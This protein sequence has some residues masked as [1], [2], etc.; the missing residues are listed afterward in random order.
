MENEIL[1]SRHRILIELFQ[2][3]IKDCEPHS[4]AYAL[5]ILGKDYSEDEVDSWLE[6]LATDEGSYGGF[7]HVA[8]VGFSLKNVTNTTKEKFEPSFLKSLKRLQNRPPS[9]IEDS[10]AVDDVALL[11]IAV[12]LSSINHIGEIEDIKTW[13]IQVIDSQRSK[14]W[15]SRMRD[16]AGDLLDP[17]GRLRKFPDFK[18]T[19][20]GALEIVLRYHWPQQ[21]ADPANATLVEYRNLLKNLLLDSPPYAGDVEKT[22]TWLNAVDLLTEGIVESLLPQTDRETEMIGTLKNITTTLNKRAEKQTN[23]T[24]IFSLLVFVVAIIVYRFIIQYYGW[25]KVEPL[26]PIID[27]SLFGVAVGYFLLTAREFSIAAFRDQILLR[28]KIKLFR[29]IGL[30][31]ESTEKLLN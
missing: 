8:S 19:N 13:L 17:R 14:N 10:L 5:C 4:K 2:D 21:F 24:M 31:I 25:D 30:D 12:G 3:S 11:G 16:L 15:T 22:A 29:R 28:K 9:V 1:S 27:L 6:N 18:I 7:P 20:V 23:L 26:T